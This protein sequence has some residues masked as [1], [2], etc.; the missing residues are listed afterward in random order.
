L[1]DDEPLLREMLR[2]AEGVLAQQ[3]HVADEA[4]DKTEQ[5]LTLVVAT[6]GGEL[7]FLAF[8]ADRHAVP[9]SAGRYMRRSPRSGLAGGRLRTT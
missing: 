4:G 1:D 6:F 8:L 9:P 2:E 7:D 3:L 5:L